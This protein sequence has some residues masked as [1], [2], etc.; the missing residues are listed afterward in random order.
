MEYGSDLD[1]CYFFL[2]LQT[3]YKP[4]HQLQCR[5]TLNLIVHKEISLLQRDLVVESD[6]ASDDQLVENSRT[7]SCLIKEVTKLVASSVRTTRC[8]WNKRVS[9]TQFIKCASLSYTLED[10]DS[11]SVRRMPTNSSALETIT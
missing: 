9:D 11:E 3:K 10:R 1:F 2:G 7:R 4:T 8:F 5:M 6:S